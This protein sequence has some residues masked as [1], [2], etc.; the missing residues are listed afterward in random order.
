MEALNPQNGKLPLSSVSPGESQ[1]GTAS[2]ADQGSKQ[3]QSLETIHA[4]LTARLAEYLDLEPSEIDISAPFS[5]YGLK[6]VDAVGLSGDLEDWLGR[7]LSPTLV[8]DYPDVIHLARYLAYGG[9]DP[10]SHD[11]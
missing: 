1:N 7:E 3:K 2:A 4:W 8:Y 5:S 6:S 11:S 9:N 10:L